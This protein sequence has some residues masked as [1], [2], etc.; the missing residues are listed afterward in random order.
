[1]SKKTIISIV[2]NLLMVLLLF[3]ML[4]QCVWYINLTRGVGDASLPEFPESE[5][6]LLASDY[7]AASETGKSHVTPYFTGVIFDDVMYGG[8]Y[9]DSLAYEIFGC[10]T[11][12]LESAP[13]GTT[14]KVVYSGNDKKYEYLDSLYN[15]TKNC[16][17]VR[18]RNSLEFSV[19]CQ[20]MSDTYIGIPENPDFAVRDMFLICG[21]SGEASITAVDNEGN[22][23]K[24]YPSKNIPFNNEYLETYNNTEKDEFEFVSVSKNRETGINCYFPCFR[25]SMDYNLVRK[26]PFSE[27]FSFNPA[28]ADLRDFVNIFGMNPDNTRFYK[29]SSDGVQVCVENATSLEIS[30]DG[31]IQFLPKGQDGT[32]DLYLDVGEESDDG[33]FGYSRASQNIVA[34]LNNKL[35]GCAGVLSLADIVYNEGECTFYYILTVNGVQ[36]AGKDVYALELRFSENRLVGAKG[37]LEVCIKDSGAV[38]DMPQRTAFVLMENAAPVRY[39]GPE[40]TLMDEVEQND[41][42]R[43]LWTVEYLSADGGVEE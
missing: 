41:C 8:T 37:H 32:L 15:D 38:T 30:A 27:F 26:V 21:S 6:A 17:Y 42:A 2:E 5:A 34:E 25:Y 9:E 4:V 1:M 36:L 11:K 3:A 35:Y 13:G 18:F 12:V 19:L 10:F 24:I 43:M 40:Y 7:L 29:R 20:L 39:F 16:Y 28:D 22:V 33:F 31:D 23:L 14:K